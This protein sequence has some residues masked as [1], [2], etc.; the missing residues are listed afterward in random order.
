MMIKFDPKVGDLVYVLWEDHCTYDGKGWLDIKEKIVGAL[1]P[2][3]CETVGFVVEVT[4]KTIT[5]VAHIARD[6]EDKED[7]DGSHVATRLRS[8]I[9]KGRIIKRFRK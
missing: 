7:E 4:P 5:T 6:Y 3:I 1:T 8:C 9:L 2:S